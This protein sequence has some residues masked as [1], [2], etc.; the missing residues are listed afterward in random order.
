MGF[1]MVRVCVWGSHMGN[2]APPEMQATER[3]G[4]SCSYGQKLM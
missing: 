2:I 1:N 3:G 4:C